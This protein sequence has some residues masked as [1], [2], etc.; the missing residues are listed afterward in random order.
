M[1]N[2]SGFFF[3]AKPCVHFPGRRLL[4]A[5]RFELNPKPHTVLLLQIRQD[6]LGLGES[7]D[8]LL[9]QLTAFSV[10]RT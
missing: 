8:K 9:R 1:G 2:H 7:L 10:D 3:I 5:L 6:D 4:P